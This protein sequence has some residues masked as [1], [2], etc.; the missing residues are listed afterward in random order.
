[1]NEIIINFDNKKRIKLLVIGLFALVG[2]AAF[3]LFLIFIPNTIYVFPI[4]FSV[5]AFIWGLVIFFIFLKSIFSNNKNG[6]ILSDEGIIFNGT[7]NGR[8]IG[9]ILWKDIDRISIGKIYST[10]FIFLKLN[11]LILD[12]YLINIRAYERNNIINNG[13]GITNNE[14]DIKFDKMKELIEAYFVKYRM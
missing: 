9:K 5:G 2:V 3:A 12:R 1:M 10:D 8:K 14:L 4:L 13:I 6:L 7:P 11:Y